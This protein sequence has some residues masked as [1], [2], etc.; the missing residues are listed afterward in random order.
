MRLQFTRNSNSPA[1]ISTR[2]I[3]YGGIGIFVGYFAL[4]H[5]SRMPEIRIMHKRSK[6]KEDFAALRDRLE[7]Y[8]RLE[9]C[10][11][12][13]AP[14]SEIAGGN[15][16]LAALDGGRLRGIDPTLIDIPLN[17]AFA[18]T[19]PWPYVYFAE[20]DAWMLL[21]TGPDCDYDIDLNEALAKFSSS[22]RSATIARTYDPT[23]G[24]FSDGDIWR[25]SE[26]LLRAP[27]GH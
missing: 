24:M 12:S 20:G 13:M 18:R 1:F 23:N 27:D 22:D 7:D 10:Y 25:A 3:V 11:P 4:M 6:V 26:S 2:W 15:K 21:S 19:H 8:H 17:D 16:E 9:G 14:F 5:M